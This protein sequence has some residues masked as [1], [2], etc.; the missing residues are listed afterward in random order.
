MI[1]WRYVYLAATVAAVVLVTSALPVLPVHLGSIEMAKMQLLSIHLQRGRVV[2][3]YHHM[4]SSYISLP[5]EPSWRNAGGFSY[6]RRTWGQL[7]TIDGSSVMAGH[8]AVPT[9]PIPVLVGLAIA[10]W[11]RP[12]R[13]ADAAGVCAGCGYDLRATP[14]RCPE[15]GKVVSKST[16]HWS[17]SGGRCPLCLLARDSLRYAS[18]A[19]LAVLGQWNRL[20]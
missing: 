2:V 8:L 11:M 12:R 14:D 13:H 1:N 3:M 4:I 15:C 5:A 6:E 17:A 20:N 18:T 16:S 9:Y 7:R 19:S 10:W